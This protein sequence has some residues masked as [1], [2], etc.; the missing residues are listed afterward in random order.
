MALLYVSC[1]PLFSHLNVT[2]LRAQIINFLILYLR[3]LF[4]I[5]LPLLFQRTF[6]GTQFS[7]NLT[8]S[9]YVGMTDEVTT[10][11]ERHNCY[12]N[13]QLHKHFQGQ[14]HLVFLPHKKDNLLYLQTIIWLMGNKTFRAA[15]GTLTFLLQRFVALNAG[16]VNCDCY[17]L[18]FLWNP[19]FFMKDYFS[20]Q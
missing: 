9:T 2:C 14:F 8:L 5:Y 11:Y 4:A 12:Q 13:Y 7:R 1:V 6:L 18:L 17:L 10:Y 15:E 19:F 3:S 16:F 20:R